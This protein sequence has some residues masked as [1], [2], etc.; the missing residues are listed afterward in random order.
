MTTSV[1]PLAFAGLPIEPR[2]SRGAPEQRDVA[3][4]IEL[5]GARMT[6]ARNAE[7]YGEAEP[8]DYLYKVVSGAVRTCKV[9]SDGRRQIGGFYL[10]GD[11]FGLEGG[12]AST[13]FRPRRSA[14][15]RCWW[16]S[17]SR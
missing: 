16:S 6:F 11:I 7:I 10:P 14:R 3:G 13:A 17:A 8:A 12:E 9:T 5:M 4:P 15:P 1:L 2:V